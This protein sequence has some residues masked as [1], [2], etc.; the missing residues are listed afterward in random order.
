[1]PNRAGDTPDGGL[2]TTFLACD[3]TTY[4]CVAANGPPAA[5][6]GTACFNP[7]TPGTGYTYVESCPQRYCLQ[8]ADP[9]L[10][11]TRSG[12]TSACWGDHMCPTGWYCDDSLSRLRPDLAYTAVCRPGPRNAVPTSWACLPGDGGAD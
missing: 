12:C 4:K 2:S 8:I 10:S 3:H 7:A 6:F 1:L 9:A 11:C 5:N